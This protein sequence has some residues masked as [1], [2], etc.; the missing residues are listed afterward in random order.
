[1]Y[2]FIFA[3]SAGRN[4]LIILAIR[5]T[6]MKTLANVFIT[7]LAVGNL[8][9]CHINVLL[10]TTLEHLG[11]WPF[12]ELMCKERHKKTIKW[13]DLQGILCGAFQIGVCKTA[14]QLIDWINV[15]LPLKLIKSFSYSD[16]MI[17]WVFR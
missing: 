13:E 16:I 12:R 9:L 17:L 11:H 6:H 1:M 10:V 5:W 14:R 4:L 3:L 8:L 15:S 2:A 7:K